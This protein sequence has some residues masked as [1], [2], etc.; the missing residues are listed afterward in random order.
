VAQ[1][2]SL[3]GKRMPKRF[4][5]FVSFAVMAALIFVVISLR[6]TLIAGSSGAGIRYYHFPWI[7]VRQDVWN[8][9]VSHIYTG[10]LLAMIA[11]SLCLT[12]VLSWVLKFLRQKKSDIAW[13]LFIL[14]IVVYILAAANPNFVLT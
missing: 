11:L 9:S 6:I 10:T 7:V 14:V 2:F 3:G 13:F 1:L 4:L 8:T 5:D 12:W